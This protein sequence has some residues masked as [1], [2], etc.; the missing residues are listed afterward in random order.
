M[1]F[2]CDIL[3]NNCYD[4]KFDDTKDNALNQNLQQKRMQYINLA[5]QHKI[6]MAPL[7]PTMTILND[8]KKINKMFEI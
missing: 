3:L 5:P 8:K 4:N 6:M 1:Y 7:E 2:N